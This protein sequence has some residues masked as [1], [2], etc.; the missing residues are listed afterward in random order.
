[1]RKAARRADRA[2]TRNEA[3]KAARAATRAPRTPAEDGTAAAVELIRA[4]R[5]GLS[6]G[7]LGTHITVITRDLLDAHP[8]QYATA[9]AWLVGQLAT[10]AAH[11][12]DQ[13]DA[14]TGD[15]QAARWLDAV[16]DHVTAH[17]T[18]RKPE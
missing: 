18:A 13:W 1:M 16:D 10:L 3:A 4:V 17:H 14:A 11:A 8:G 7:D 15:P 2:A 6:T 12:C 9:N 5:N